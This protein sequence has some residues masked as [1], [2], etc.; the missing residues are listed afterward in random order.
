MSEKIQPPPAALPYMICPRCNTG[1]RMPHC[2][3]CGNALTSNVYYGRTCEALDIIIKKQ[4]KGTQ[5][6][7][8]KMELENRRHAK[9]MKGLRREEE[10]RTGKYKDLVAALEWAEYYDIYADGDK[11]DGERSKKGNP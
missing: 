2:G 7:W 8:D 6:V 5:L 10:L 4:K 3:V 11:S 9:V 1:T